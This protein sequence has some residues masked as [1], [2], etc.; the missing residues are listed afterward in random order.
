MVYLTE[1]VLFMVSEINFFPLKI[2][3][4]IDLSLS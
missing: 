4:H 1:K 3:E 2:L